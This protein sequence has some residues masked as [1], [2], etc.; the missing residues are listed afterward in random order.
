MKDKTEILNDRRVLKVFKDVNNGK[1]SKLK[2][3][4]RS[5]KASDK[6]LVCMTCI[7]GWEHLSVSHKNKIPSWLC[8]EEMK[9][10][11]FNDDEEAFQ[12]HPKMENYVNNNEYTLHIWRKQDGTM[13]TPPSILVGFRPN[14]LE[15]D[16]KTAKELHERIGCPLSDDE[17]K[18][19]ALGGQPDGQKKIADAVKSM[20][21]DELFKWCAKMGVI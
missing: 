15:E 14:F 8:M 11:F 9:E 12:F 6:C 7:D 18:L 21:P 4:V 20:S 17:I 3:E 16:M 10:M 1:V 19:M 5:N 13:S 2:L